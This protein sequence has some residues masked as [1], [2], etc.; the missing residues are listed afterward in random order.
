MTT[1]DHQVQLAAWPTPRQVDGEKHSRTM[2]GADKEIARKGGPQDLMQG[3]QLAA[4]PTPAARDWKDGAAP[5]VVNSG[6]TDKLAHVVQPPTTGP[7]RLTDSGQL[8]T[9]S[10]AGTGNGD[11]LNPAL[12]RWLMGLPQEWDACAPTEMPSSRKSR[13]K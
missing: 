2:E 6:R 3:V 9:G 10:S 12:S 11:R 4:S 8:L 13:R 5:S 7:A 1:L